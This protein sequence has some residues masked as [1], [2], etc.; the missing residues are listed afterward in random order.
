ETLNV[1]LSIARRIG[2]G[3]GIFILVVGIVFYLTNNTLT[4]SYNI[5]KKINEVY[6]PSIKVLEELDNQLVRSQQL[7]KQWAYVQRR[8]DDR[9]RLDATKLCEITIPD[10][11]QK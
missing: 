2:F 4:E 9:E 8:E 5:N 11:L 6:A 10:Q 3:F 7:M 1:R